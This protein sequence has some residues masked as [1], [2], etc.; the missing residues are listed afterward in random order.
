MKTR[1]CSVFFSSIT[2]NLLYQCSPHHTYRA[3]GHMILDQIQIF[4]V[5][6][7][8]HYIQFI[9]LCSNDEAV[10]HFH[11]MFYIQLEFSMRIFHLLFCS[12][13]LS[14][15]CLFISS[16]LPFP[17]IRDPS[18]RSAKIPKTIHPL[19]AKYSLSISFYSTFR[20]II[21]FDL[22][23][24]ATYIY[25]NI[26]TYECICAHLEKENSKQKGKKEENV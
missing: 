3:D 15:I 12:L 8:Q 2:R 20:G 23:I 25:R 16:F 17:K 6:R 18:H 7:I 10:F 5:F 19:L 4:T 24:L 13:S 1:H 22:M 11:T 21:H 14:S 26:C 9:W